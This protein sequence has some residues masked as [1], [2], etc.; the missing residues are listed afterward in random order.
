MT[1]E[2]AHPVTRRELREELA[3]YPTR[4]ELHEALDIWARVLEDRLVIRI[5]AHTSSEIARHV[6]ASDELIRAD[7]R[8]MLEPHDGVPER[9]SGLEARVDRLEAKVLAPK[10]SRRR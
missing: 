3:S 6:T 9:V 7:V 4:K 2:M 10:R 5:N 1:D 8:T